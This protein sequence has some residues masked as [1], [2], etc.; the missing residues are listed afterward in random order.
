M[1]TQESNEKDCEA[2]SKSTRA[3][4]LSRYVLVTPARNEAQF[5]ELTLKSVVAQ[6]IRPIK[7][8][9]VSDGSTDGTDE[10]VKR[11]IVENPWIELVR[12]PERSERHFAGKVLAF[13][14]GY[15]SVENLEYEAIGN[16][17][18]DSSFDKDYFSFLLDRLSEDGELGLVGT[19][20]TN[21]HAPSDVR[22]PEP[23]RSDTAYDYR[24]A[25]SE[26][27]P[28]IC[29]L[30]RRQCFEDIG[31]YKAV[32]GGGIDFI[33]ALTAKAAGW[34]TRSFREKVAV[35]HRANGTA[36]TGVLVAEF[37][38]GARDYAVGNHPAWESFRVLY[39]M[40]KRP[41]LIGGLAQ[42]CGYL[43]SLV[44]RTE[45]PIS[46]ELVALH[47]QEQMQRLRRVV[48]EWMH[49]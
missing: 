48:G 18:G 36:E 4:M 22:M 8:V 46:R 34:K 39:H 44:R 30:F 47:R 7:W 5:I 3:S 42:L 24:F 16:L 2:H 11:Y 13:N 38:N 43:W 27:V 26:H 1:V 19:A 10:I 33:A 40:S 6:T 29:Q 15:A 41:I 20:Y 9:I 31:G 28:G 37:R 32:K 25:S 17:D 23:S 12:M 45:R 21:D 49:K 14:A 35:H